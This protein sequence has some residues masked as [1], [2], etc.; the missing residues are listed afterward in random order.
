MTD[1]LFPEAKQDSPFVEFVKRHGI[2]TVCDNNGKWYA[3]EATTIREFI[4]G[5]YHA[6]EFEDKNDS[7]KLAMMAMRCATNMIQAGQSEKDA[8]RTFARHWEL[9]GWEAVNW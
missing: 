8:V 2:V 1:D 7:E 3:S 4:G 6:S 9:D 5:Y